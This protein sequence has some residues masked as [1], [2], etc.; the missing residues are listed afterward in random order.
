MAIQTQYKTASTRRPLGFGWLLDVYV[1]IF[2][3]FML[4]P[5]IAV[6]V[7]SFNSTAFISFPFEAFSLRWYYRI[8]EY[9]PFIRSMVTSLQ[10]AFAATFAAC[11]LGVPAA[12]TL[13]RDRS[14]IGGALTAFLLMPLAVPS[15]VLGFALLYFLGALNF[16]VSFLS[17][18]ISHT[19]ILV[20]YIVRTVLAVYR[21][22]SPHYA[23]AAAILGAN[24]VRV[25]YHV[26]LPLIRPGIFAGSLFSLLISF[27]NVPV[28]FFFSSADSVTLPI[29]MLNYM[30]NQFDPSIAAISTVQMAIAFIALLTVQRL[31]GLK[32][33]VDA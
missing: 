15:I 12:L 9:K 18:W 24:P 23:E 33:I 27:D 22:V 4:A 19:V 14:K 20:P 21:G 5:I 32:G 28:S 13:A 16:G 2:F 26:T 1:I 8:V 3:V 17:L 30:E 25:F 31:F 29:V 7:I 10:L 6:I 11:L